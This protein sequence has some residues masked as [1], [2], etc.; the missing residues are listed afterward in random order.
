MIGGLTALLYRRATRCRVHYATQD[1][2]EM[3]CSRHSFRTESMSALQEHMLEE[4]AT[5]AKALTR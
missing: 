5:T 4:L 1:P 3:T 2:Y